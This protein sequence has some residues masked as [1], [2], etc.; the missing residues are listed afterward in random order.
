M[1]MSSF[2]KQK[3]QTEYLTLV[4]MYMADNVLLLRQITPTSPY[5][6]LLSCKII[7]RL[8]CLWEFTHWWINDRYGSNSSQTHLLLRIFR[9]ALVLDCSIYTTSTKD[10]KT[11]N[12]ELMSYT[13]S[14]K[15][16]RHSSSWGYSFLTFSWITISVGTLSDLRLQD[17]FSLLNL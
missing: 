4:E 12:D 7:A 2:P 17:Q 14:K 5:D 1:T 16:V 11:S 8:C 3:R 15:S 6:A 13:G 10:N 9:A